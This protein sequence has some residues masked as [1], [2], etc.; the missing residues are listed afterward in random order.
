LGG[1]T[2]FLRL[3]TALSESL[4]LIQ[5]SAFT[6]WVKYLAAFCM[7]EVSAVNIEHLS[8]SLSWISVSV[9]MISAPTLWSVIDASV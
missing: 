7:A 4:R 6:D 8:D 9:H 5:R 3:V 2:V 1:L